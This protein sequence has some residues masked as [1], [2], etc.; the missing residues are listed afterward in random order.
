MT[1][2]VFDP[3]RGGWVPA[4]PLPFFGR[5]LLLKPRFVCWESVM[6]APFGVTTVSK[7]RRRFKT[8]EAYERHYRMAHLGETR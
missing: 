6:D 7:C 3:D 8:L 5:S 2:D 1:V 4:I